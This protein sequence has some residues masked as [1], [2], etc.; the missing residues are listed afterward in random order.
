[1]GDEGAGGIGRIA[2]AGAVA[3]GLVAVFVV[4]LAR[5]Q[6]APE[7]PVEIIWDQE[8]CAHCRMHIGEPA[9]AAQLQTTAREV[10]NFDDPGCLFAYLEERRPEVQAVYLRHV[11]EERW[12]RA[13]EAAFE[14]VEHSPMGYDIGAVDREWPGAM[15]YESGRALVLERGQRL[16]QA[17]E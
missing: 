15:S 4:L 6:Q 8:S 13:D 5:A 2:L 1:M 12:L 9:F 16:G 10:F 3:A 7:G 11:W 17:G 14:R